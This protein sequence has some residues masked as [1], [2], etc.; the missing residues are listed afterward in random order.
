M[1]RRHQ[2]SYSNRYTDEFVSV[3]LILKQLQDQVNQKTSN[4]FS[5][6]WRDLAYSPNITDA[7]VLLR[8][9]WYVSGWTSNSYPDSCMSY[10][11]ARRNQRRIN[12][13]A[14]EMGCGQPPL[15]GGGR[16]EKIRRSS[17]AN[18]ANWPRLVALQ[19]ALAEACKASM[20][21]Q[22]GRRR[23]ITRH[24]NSKLTIVWC[25]VI[26]RVVPRLNRTCY[27]FS[28]QL[29]QTFSLESIQKIVYSRSRIGMTRIKTLSVEHLRAPK[30]R[31][32]FLC[33]WWY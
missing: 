19:G 3:V 24:G 16:G 2:L 18:R 15:R 23:G 27:K 7:S 6:K 22:C 1:Q 26:T 9:T 13:Y 14:A 4:S 28:D 17:P 32:T 31:H 30:R 12:R 10:A 8:N 20:H 21:A 29:F 33:F 25:C 11:H 5:V